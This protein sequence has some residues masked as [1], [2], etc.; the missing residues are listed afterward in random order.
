MAAEVISITAARLHRV[1][2]ETD[3][4]PYKIT[5]HT[6]VVEVVFGEG[7]RAVELW[8]SVRQGDDFVGEFRGAV[9]LAAMLERTR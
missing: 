6:G 9:D 2:G 5:V 7:E 1:T 8:F 3:R 4:I